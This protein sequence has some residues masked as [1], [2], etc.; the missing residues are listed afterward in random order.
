MLGIRRERCVSHATQVQVAIKQAQIDNRTFLNSVATGSASTQSVQAAHSTGASHIYEVAYN[1]AIVALR[2][3]D[4]MMIVDHQDHK[5]SDFVRTVEALMQKAHALRNKT[6]PWE[7]ETQIGQTG[8]RLKVHMA[9]DNTVTMTYQKD[10]SASPVQV[11]P[12]G[13][14]DWKLTH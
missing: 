5:A 11:D 4:R 7:L 9:A 1:D 12:I 8:S 6:P 3:G 2:V 13:R 10:A 14:L